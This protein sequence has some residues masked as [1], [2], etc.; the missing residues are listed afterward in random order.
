MCLGTIYVT[1]TSRNLFIK[2][3]FHDWDYTFKASSNVANRQ[4]ATLLM[5]KLNIKFNVNP[6]KF[7]HKGD[8]ASESEHNSVLYV[9][10]LCSAVTLAL[11]VLTGWHCNLISRGETSIECHIN[12]GEAKNLKKQGLVFRNPYNFGIWKN[13]RMVLG[14]VEGRS[15]L[16]ILIPSVHLP[17]GDG[18]TWLPPPGNVKKNSDRKLHIV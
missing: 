6:R 17:Y 7:H 4:N 5:S 9:F 18:I 16:R 1:V 3:F 11:G 13:W 10:M 12:K 2:H 14:L 8:T 15:W